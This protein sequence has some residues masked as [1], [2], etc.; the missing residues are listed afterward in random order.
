MNVSA[1]LSSLAG[2]EYVQP[3]QIKITVV[4]DLNKKVT[5]LVYTFDVKM[6]QIFDKIRVKKTPK[7]IQ[8]FKIESLF[9]S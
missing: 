7:N 3:F 6:L 8:I 5:S 9:M 2:F 4:S 1:H